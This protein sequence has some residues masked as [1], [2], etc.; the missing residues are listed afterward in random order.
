MAL[1]MRVLVSRSCSGRCREDQRRDFFKKQWLENNLAHL[2]DPVINLLYSRLA[3]MLQ[4]DALDPDESLELLNILRSFSGLGIERSKVGGAFA[5]AP[6]D[7]PFNSPA[8]DLLWDGRMFVFTGVMA[9]G[10][11]GTDHDFWLE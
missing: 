7:L 3:S 8:P 5:V 2:N 4:D 10:F 1:G 6:T 9:F 11:E